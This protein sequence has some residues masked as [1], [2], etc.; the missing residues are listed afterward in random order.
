MKANIWAK[1]NKKNTRINFYITVVDGIKKKGIINRTTIPT[2]IAIDQEFWDIK[3]KE[4]RNHP[5][6]E[7]IK[8]DLETMLINVRSFINDNRR[9][10]I[11]IW[12][13]KAHFV[14]EKLEKIDFIDA[15]TDLLN[16]LELKK[17]LSP[18]TIAA[19]RTDFKRVSKIM[20]LMNISPSLDEVGVETWKAIEENC[21]SDRLQNSTTNNILKNFK[22]WMNSFKSRGLVDASFLKDLK[23][24]KAPIKK[25]PYLSLEELEKIEQLPLE[26]K[27][28]IKVRDMILVHKDVGLRCGD[29]M[30]LSLINFNLETNRIE[31]ITRKNKRE[32]SLPISP[33]ISN[34]LKKYNYNLPT[35]SATNYNK[36][37]KELC[38]LAGITGTVRTVKYIGNDTIEEWVEKYKIIASHTFRRSFITNGLKRGVSSSSMMMLV[39]STDEKVFTNYNSLTKEDASNEYASMMNSSK[40]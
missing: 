37:I 15:V 13:V 7:T 31:L 34:L 19:H 5:D 33:I 27:K 4:I 39:G 14:E 26:D 32:L 40:K 17:E 9:K 3:K 35:M 2:G 24:L 38:R 6:K 8:I 23:K 30:N 22:K 25:Y 18:H 20:K 12:D 21:I 1:K 10:N 11:T 28:L 16:E 29:L 36:G